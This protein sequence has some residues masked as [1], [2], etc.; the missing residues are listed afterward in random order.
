VS[1]RPFPFLVLAVL[2][3]SLPRGALTQLPG[4]GGCVSTPGGHP[5][6]AHARGLRGAS[7][8]A[9]SPDGKSVYATSDFA[10]KGAIAVF[11]RDP[12]THALTQLRGSAGCVSSDGSGGSCAK[13]AA[14]HGTTA[15]AVSPDGRNV[16]AISSYGHGDGIS[17]FARD[18]RT[19]ALAQFPGTDGCITLTGTAGACA[20]GTETFFVGGVGSIAVSAD[21]RSVYAVS[22]GAVDVFA[23]DP[24]TG[25]LGQLAKP[26]GCVGGSSSAGSCTKGRGLLDAKVVAVSPDGRNVYVA[27]GSG[28]SNTPTGDLAVFER[29]P[30]TGALT[31]ATDASGCLSETDSTC[32]RA[33][34]DVEDPTAVVVSPDGR[35]VYLAAFGLVTFSRTAATGALRPVGK[36]AFSASDLALSPDSLNLYAPAAHENAVDVF[37]RDRA[38]GGLR[39]LPAPGGCV[40]EKSSRCARARPLD[41]LQAV[42]ASSDGRNVYVVARDAVVAFARRG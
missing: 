17:V 40:A 3:V 15:I 19:G 20:T 8:L 37:S 41:Q 31:Q 21:G 14:L 30:A 4:P 33:S 1:L 16:Y 39:P 35:F 32:A 26:L 42:A 24:A 36:T 23:R 2:A 9:V 25:A 12:R 7:A 11:A 22:V 5:G 29:D 34:P 6:C 28:D 27:G 18:P 10:G 38:T 13:G